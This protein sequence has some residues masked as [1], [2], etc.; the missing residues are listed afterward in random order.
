LRIERKIRLPKP[1]TAETRSARREKE[2][3]FDKRIALSLYC[4]SGLPNP[5]QNLL[6]L[7]GFGNP[8]KPEK[9]TLQ[10]QQGRRKCT[11]RAL[12]ILILPGD[13]PFFRE[14]RVQKIFTTKTTKFTKFHK[15]FH[16]ILVHFEPFENFVVKVLKFV[17]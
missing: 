13:L 6:K 12:K 16:G 14:F 4:C 17:R 3:I 7:A 5:G 11:E 15:A 2:F 10:D 9:L 8:A 1:L